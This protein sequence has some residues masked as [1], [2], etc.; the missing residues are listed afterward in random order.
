MALRTHASL[1]E[2]QTDS[3]KTLKN[4]PN[5]PTDWVGT[6]QDSVRM[7]STAHG[8][9]LESRRTGSLGLAVVGSFMIDEIIDLVKEGR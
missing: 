5:E 1:F 3:L 9:S 8:E 7:Y 2:R 4:L 6:T